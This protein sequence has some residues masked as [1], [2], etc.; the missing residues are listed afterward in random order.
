MNLPTKPLLNR[1]LRQIL[2]FLL[3][4]ACF[5]PAAAPPLLAA[6][7]H[8]GAEKAKE[9][10]ADTK[11]PGVRSVPLRKPVV[12]APRPAAS[13]SRGGLSGPP[14]AATSISNAFPDGICTTSGSA[15]ASMTDPCA[16]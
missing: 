6:G 16:S 7:E 13:E 14:A 1:R 9:P 3:A 8:E 15:S 5:A 12:V 11:V 10:P 2:L 4:A